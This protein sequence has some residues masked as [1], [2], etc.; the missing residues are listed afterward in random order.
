MSK[1]LEVVSGAVTSVNQK[2]NGIQVQGFEG[3]LNIS[4]YHPVPV[5][6]TVGELV[7][8]Q[9]E[10]T[11]KGAWINSLRIIGG[12]PASGAPATSRDRTITRLACLKAAAI[13]CSG[14]SVS[15]DVKSS[16]VLAIAEAWL[17]WVERED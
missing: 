9:F 15:N 5:V 4:Q 2:K 1:Q 7:E 13:F 12:G 3:W 10:Q 8:V 16:D 11:D 17:K 6:P 14:R